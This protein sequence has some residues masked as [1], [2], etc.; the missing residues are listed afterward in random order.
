MRRKRS[1]A[2]RRILTWLALLCLLAGYI[3]WGNSA[4]M[5]MLI[6]FFIGIL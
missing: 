1:S 4:V 6:L 3:L 2:G 5:V